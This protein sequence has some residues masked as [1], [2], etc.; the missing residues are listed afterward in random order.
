[1][2]VETRVM[3]CIM[4]PMGCE[5]TV[6]IEDGKVTNVTGNTCPRG[7]KYANDEVTAPKRMLTS[8]VAIE[9]GVLPLL[10][11]VS[12]T[13]LPKERVM[14]C[15]RFLRSVKINAPVKAGDVV[16]ENILGL[17]VNIVASRNMEL[18]Q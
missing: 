2:A 18:H 15:A 5:L 3:N 1:M 16:V 9:G 6:T 12:A 14:D 10:P 4:C 11:V 7:P 13:V 8:T 17:G